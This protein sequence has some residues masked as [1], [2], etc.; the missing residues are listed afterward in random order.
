MVA[1]VRFIVLNPGTLP[2]AQV[3]ALQGAGYSG[4]QVAHIALAI[5]VITSPTYSIAS[6]TPFWIS[7]SLS[8]DRAKHR[9]PTDPRHECNSSSSSGRAEYLWGLKD[10]PS[11]K[12]VDQAVDVAVHAFLNGYAGQRP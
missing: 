9:Y 5:S 8:N 3:E 10:A 1:F 11:D 7:P 12:Q 4:E 6:T 2:A